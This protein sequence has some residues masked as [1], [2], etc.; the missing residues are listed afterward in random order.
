MVGVM[1]IKYGDQEGKN[2]GGE[3]AECALHSTLIALV[4]GE[5]FKYRND[6]RLGDRIGI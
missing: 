3:T 6:G 4:D 5:A 2:W 1:H